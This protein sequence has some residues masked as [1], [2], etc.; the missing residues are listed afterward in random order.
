MEEGWKKVE[1]NTRGAFAS[2]H[3]ALQCSKELQPT[4]GTDA[5]LFLPSYVAVRPWL[6]F[7]VYTRARTYNTTAA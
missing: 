3:N 1:A 7:L 4:A 2:S 5:A 6:S